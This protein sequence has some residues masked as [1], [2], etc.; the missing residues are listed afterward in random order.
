MAL[1]KWE[2]MRDI[3]NLLDRYTLHLPWP[4][5]R[6]S[7]MLS[8]GEWNPRVDI[9]EDDGTYVIQAD[10]PGVAKDDLK[11][12]LDNGV[13]TIQGERKQEKEEENKRF[14]RVERLYGS[15]TRSFTLPDDADAS[16]L[17][18][19]AREGQLSVTIPRKVT[20]P[21][22]DAVQVPVE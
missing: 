16:A 18:A 22:T 3:E 17:K 4:P 20:S 9:V 5:S 13:L 10:I 6:P 12:T 8:M 1:T 11:V 7:S 15:F 19:T 21:P 14:H 2:P